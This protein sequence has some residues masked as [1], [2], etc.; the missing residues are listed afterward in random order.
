MMTFEA[1]ARE[2]FV[3]AGV[4]DPPIERV[5]EVAQILTDK[6][7][8]LSVTMGLTH[9]RVEVFNRQKA[10]L[11]EDIKNLVKMGEL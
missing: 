3:E 11:V 1:T 2:L 9:D 5:K 7:A 8:M 10:A 4:F 6:M